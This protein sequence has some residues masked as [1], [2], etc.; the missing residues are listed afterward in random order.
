MC[1]RVYVPGNECVRG[2]CVRVYV[3]RNECV[4]GCVYLRM[5]V[6]EGVCT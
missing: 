5:S 3:T 6:C 2:V 4:L 1:V